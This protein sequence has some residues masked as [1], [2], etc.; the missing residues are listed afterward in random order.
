[1]LLTSFGFASPDQAAPHSASYPRDLQRGIDAIRAFEVPG[2][3]CLAREWGSRRFGSVRRQR[4]IQS[5][6]NWL[7]AYLHRTYPER[8]LF[9]GLD[10]RGDR[11]VYIVLLTG[12]QHIPP[13]R[14][15]DRAANVP[16]IIEYG[17]P[18]SF[19]EIRHRAG[20][21]SD[22]PQRLGRKPINGIPSRP[23]F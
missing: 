18:L 7:N 1:M 8:L 2:R 3:P 21:A 5:D 9:S 20:V 14:L 15:H 19:A 11:F 16:V 4:E 10:W 12:R 22:R 17:A 23:I 13:Q 6:S